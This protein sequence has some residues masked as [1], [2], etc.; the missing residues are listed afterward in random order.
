MILLDVFLPNQ[1]ISFGQGLIFS[2][3]KLKEVATWQD[4]RASIG[5]LCHKF[6]RSMETRKCS[7]KSLTPPQSQS[8]ITAGENWLRVYRVRDL[9]LPQA[10]PFTPP[11][12][13]QVSA[14]ETPSQAGFPAHTALQWAALGRRGCQSH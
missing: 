3:E 7:S 12:C 5:N 2:W 9:Q 1:R 14:P 6:G 10:S 4:N 8:S 11:E 13:L